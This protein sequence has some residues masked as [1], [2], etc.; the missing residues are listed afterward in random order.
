[1]TLTASG[2][3]TASGAISQLAP[4]AT[5]ATDL[6]VGTQHQRRRAAERLGHRKFRLRSRRR[7]HLADRAW[8]THTS[9]SFGGVYRL[10][11][12][13]ILP[14]TLT[15]HVGDSGDQTIT[16]TNIDP[17]DGY[18]ENLIATVVGTTGALTASGTTG[19]IA[20]QA[21]GT[22]A[23]KFSTATAGSVG[24]VTLDLKSDGT[25]IDGL[26]M[27]D[28]GDVTIPVA[29]TSGN[30][31]AAAQFEELSGGGTFTPE[32]QRLQSQSRHDHGPHNRESGRA[33][34][35]G[36]RRPIRW[37]AASRSA[38]LP[39]SPTAALTHSQASAQVLPTLLRR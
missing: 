27:T 39:N 29:V 35:R 16:I 3:A 38:A 25:G 24:T 34:Q 8:P 19:D 6:S 37:R 32:R 14:N 21:D 11:D 22:I 26:G 30:V 7:Q 2:K 23:V 31:P 36:R 18:S 5:D 12:P 9:T 13:S 28:L 4:G 33:Q 10:A 15:V 20:P 17:N 1:M